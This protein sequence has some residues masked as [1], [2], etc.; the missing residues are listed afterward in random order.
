M[1]E[2]LHEA[3]AYDSGSAQ[4]ANGNLFLHDVA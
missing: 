4:D 2:H 3:L 1:L